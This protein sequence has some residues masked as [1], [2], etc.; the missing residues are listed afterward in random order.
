M[1]AYDGVNRLY[2]TVQATGRVFYVDLTSNRVYP[3]GVTPYAQGAVAIGNRMEVQYTP[4][5]VGFVYIMRHTGQE[6]WRSL[7]YP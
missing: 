1:Y 3:A 7:I 2:F 4:D 5:G 6:L